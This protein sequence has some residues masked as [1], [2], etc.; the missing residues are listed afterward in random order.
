MPALL[1]LLLQD[2]DLASRVVADGQMD[3]A[4]LAFL[5]VSW[6]CVL[7]LTGWAFARILRKP[8]PS[9]PEL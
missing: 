2:A 7:G 8:T 6:A 5:A 4:A 3:P 9:A 1:L